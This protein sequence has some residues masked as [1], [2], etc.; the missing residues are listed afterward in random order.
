MK[1]NAVDANDP[2]LLAATGKESDLRKKLRGWD[3]SMSYDSY[4]LRAPGKTIWIA[5]MASDDTTGF[6][7]VEEKAMQQTVTLVTADTMRSELAA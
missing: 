5:L 6:V 4:V 1:V 3:R 7:V 2:G